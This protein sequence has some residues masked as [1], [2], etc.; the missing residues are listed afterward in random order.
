MCVI[1]ETIAFMG[2][3]DM[4]FGRW[5]TPQHILIDDGNEAKSESD[6]IWPGT[7]SRPADI[8]DVELMRL[9]RSVGKDYSNARVADFHT[10]N[11]PHEDMY[12]RTKV[13]RMPWSVLIGLCCPLLIL[14][15]KGMISVS[16]LLVSQPETC[17][18]ILSNGEQIEQPFELLIIN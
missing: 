16:R 12:D 1:D 18:A 2:G 13:P 4:C 5:D 3:F 7:S 11:K 10:L 8:S 9:F 14:Y 15:C 6:H 17:A